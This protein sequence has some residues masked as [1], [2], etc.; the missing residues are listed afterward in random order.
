MAEPIRID[1]LCHLTEAPDATATE[2]GQKLYT[3]NPTVHRHLE[4][5]VRLG[6]VS[7]DRGEG[8][9]MTPGRPPTRFSLEPDVRSRLLVFLRL[10]S[11]PLLPET[12]RTSSP[13]PVR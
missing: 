12:R 9:G 5:L 11:K 7:E 6:L 1:I 3:S 10:L 13:A 2:L 8:D 4:V